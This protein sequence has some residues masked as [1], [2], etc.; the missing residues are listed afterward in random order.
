MLN[1]GVEARENPEG[2]L[3]GVFEGVELEVYDE[4]DEPIDKVSEI[5]MVHL[6]ILY[7]Q[8]LIRA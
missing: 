2:L 7:L 1:V 4:I 8:Y 5:E 3:V 6:L